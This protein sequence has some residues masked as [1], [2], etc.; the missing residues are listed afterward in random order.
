[1]NEKKYSMTS[2]AVIGIVVLLLGVILT[3]GNFDIIE[4]S[5]VLRFW[6]ALLVLFGMLKAL[7]PGPGGGRLFGAGVTV[8]GIFM[9]LGR[10]DI[11]WFDLWDL[12]PLVLIAVGASLV[13]KTGR[14]SAEKRG[15]STEQ[16]LTGSAVLGGIEQRNSSL[17][18]RGGSAR[19]FSAG[20]K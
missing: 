14:R 7:Q 19:P 1:M 9:L 8:V 17:D 12:W 11:I 10:L 3:L 20:S 15:E 5:S 6:P 4:A 18:F 13:L 2:Q 16:Y